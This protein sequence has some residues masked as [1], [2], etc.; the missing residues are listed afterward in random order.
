[1]RR[2]PDQVVHAAGCR[3][4][5]VCRAEDHERTEGREEWHG[6]FNEGTPEFERCGM[7]GD[8]RM[9]PKTTNGG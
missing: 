6:L 8:E 4:R 2:L 9:N 1:M 3:I 5:R 7:D